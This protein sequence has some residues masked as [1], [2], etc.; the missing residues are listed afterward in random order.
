MKPIFRAALVAA[1]CAAGAAVAVHAEV[2]EQI[3]V[4]VNGDI[5]TKTELEQRQIMVLR[6]RN[7]QLLQDDAALKQA[8]AEI[9]PRL[10]VDTIDEM[11]LTQRGRE[12]GYR[13]S[14]E[15]FRGILDNIKK[16]NKLD[17]E[18]QFQ[19]AL[20]QE[21]MT[22]DELR[23]S[24]E[25][26][27]LIDRVQQLEV[28]QKVGITE[29]EARQYYAEHPGEFTTPSAVTLREILVAVPEATSGGERG[30]N[31]AQDDAAREKAEA[32]RARIAAGEE[33]AKVAAEVSDAPSKANGGL[34]GPVSRNELAPALAKVLDALKPGEITEPVRTT[35]GYQI[36]KLETASET[37]LQPFEQVRDQIAERV[38]NEKRRGELEKYLKRLRAQAIIEWKSDELRKMYEQQVAAA[39]A[40]P[41]GL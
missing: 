25:T 37:T 7:P 30:I 6:Q 32:A 19:A 4:K 10:L 41:A 5:L 12:L 29:D 11:L 3:L 34:I 28:M 17:S 27:M 8:L 40:T 33:F 24:I 20:K 38:Y 26:R 2:L 23:R 16:E 13:L 18:E 31:V 1:A 39:P 15:Q 35:R 21:G 9:T 36:I 22:L 14:D